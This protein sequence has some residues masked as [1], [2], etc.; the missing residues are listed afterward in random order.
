MSPAETFGTRAVFGIPEGAVRLA[1]DSDK[2]WRVELDKSSAPS[3]G[4]LVLSI[5]PNANAP[6]GRY[7]VKA[8]HREAETVLAKLVVLFNPWC[9]GGSVSSVTSRLQPYR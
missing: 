8:K 7:T 9:K 5:T 4:L 6:I 1:M 2:W 3:T